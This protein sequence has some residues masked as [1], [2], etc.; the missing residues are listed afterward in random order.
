MKPFREAANKIRYSGSL[1]EADF[2]VGYR[3]RMAEGGLKEVPLREFLETGEVPDHR[4][5]WI[6]DRT[7]NFVWHREEKVC[8]I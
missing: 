8:D 3:D 4:V 7:G 5:A 6:K 1:D 2:T